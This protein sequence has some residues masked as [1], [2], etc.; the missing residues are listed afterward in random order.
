MHLPVEENHHPL[1]F[2][3]VR[4]KPKE[5]GNAHCSIQFQRENCIISLFYGGIMII[6]HI[7]V[8]IIVSIIIIIIIPDLLPYQREWNL[9]PATIV[10]R[11]LITGMPNTFD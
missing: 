1:Y 9:L 6:D 2:W 4:L 5:T 7:E 8:I 10:H 3:I 11:I